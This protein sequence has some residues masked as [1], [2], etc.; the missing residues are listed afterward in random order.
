MQ[1]DASV[2]DGGGGPAAALETRALEMQS[3]FPYRLAV[4]AEDVSRCV[5][6]IY[7]DRFSLTRHE[8]RMLAALADLGA[9][10]ATDLGE[11]STL[12]K[13]QVSRALGDLEG[14]GLVS[15]VA[16]RADRRTK[17]VRLTPAG[18][19]LFRT[20]VPLVRE[21]ERA[22]LSVLSPGDQATLRGAIDALTVAARRLAAARPGSGGGQILPGG[23]ADA[24]GAAGLGDVERL[25]RPPDEVGEA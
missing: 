1:D 24:V 7:Q 11:F 22:L 14:R 8:W 20:M 6:A 13:M 25:L 5:A 17:Q 16:G 9:A 19:R 3:F 4:L 10:T 23:D 12:D 18:R 2:E 15:R 21:R